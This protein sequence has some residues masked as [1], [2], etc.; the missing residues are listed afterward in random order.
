MRRGWVM[1]D[2]TVA[3]LLI[4]TMAG[5]LAYTANRQQ[6]H[7]QF[8]ADTRS[9]SRIAEAALITLQS[10]QTSLPPGITVHP[11][12]R[13]AEIPGMVWVQVGAIEAGRTA[14]LVGLVPQA[15]LPRDNGAQP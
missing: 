1:L 13:P 9:A 2:V 12:S 11:L 7:L 14:S 10:G 8:L 6:T 5:V 4:S 15:S 3:L